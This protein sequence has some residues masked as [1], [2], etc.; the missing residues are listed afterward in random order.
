[1]K[2]VE[3]IESVEGKIPKRHQSSTKGL[4]VYKDGEK[5]NGDYAQYRIMMAAACT[6]GN[7]VPDMDQKSWVGKYKT[8][9]PYS[10]EDDK[11]LKMAYKAAGASYKD[12]NHGDLKS[13][14]LDSTNTVSP[15]AKIKKNRYGV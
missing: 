14:E 3:L 2:I 8:S 9:H 1:M 10:K 11:K 6:D 12:L 7:K 4:H 15:V 5:W 13:Q